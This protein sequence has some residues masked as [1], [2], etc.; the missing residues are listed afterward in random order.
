MTVNKIV[1]EDYPA[2]Q[3]PEDLRP[4]A[5]P[6]ARVTVIVAEEQGRPERVLSL[7]EIWAMRRPP[8]RTKDDIDA[9][10]RHQRDEWDE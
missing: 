3:L 9:E 5:D 1:R 6:N 7:E 10:V 2:S 4:S 8:Y